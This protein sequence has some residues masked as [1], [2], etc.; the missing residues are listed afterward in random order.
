M[1][2]LITIEISEETEAKLIERYRLI[3][4]TNFD[5]VLINELSNQ[6]CNQLYSDVTI[7]KMAQKDG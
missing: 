5:P 7:D 1:T 2:K 3:F 6:I 4:E